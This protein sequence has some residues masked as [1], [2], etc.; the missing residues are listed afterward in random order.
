MI[1]LDRPTPVGRGL[2]LGPP[3]PREPSPSRPSP[4]ASLQTTT[5]REAQRKHRRLSDKVQSI[6]TVCGFCICKSTYSPKL[7]V[8]PQAVLLARTR[9]FADTCMQSSQ[10]FEC[11]MH[12]FPDDIIPLT[13]DEQA[14]FSRSS[15]CHILHIFVLFVGDFTV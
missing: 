4:S 5:P 12:V 11:L 8:T 7:L 2:T 14:S 9:S 1:V 13:Y 15:E 6:L 10:K 3:C